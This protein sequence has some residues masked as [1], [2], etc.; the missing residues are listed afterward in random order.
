MTIDTAEWSLFLKRKDEKNF[1]AYIAAWTVGWDADLYQ[2]W[3]SSQADIPKGSN[4]IGFRNK[5][6]DKLIEALRVSMDTD[7]RTKLLQAFHRLVADEQPYSFFQ[8]PKNVICSTMFV[9]TPD[10]Q[11]QV[12]PMP[13]GRR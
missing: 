9:A 13:R 6:A 4:S 8:S 1:D 7:E 11:R 2:I 12:T 10:G 5:E 3:H